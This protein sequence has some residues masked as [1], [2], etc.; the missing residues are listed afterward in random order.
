M[1]DLALVTLTCRLG[2]CMCQ[3]VRMSLYGRPGACYIDLPADFIS[4]QTD[5]NKVMYVAAAAL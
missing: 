5:Y 1:V 4:Q 2:V 3:A